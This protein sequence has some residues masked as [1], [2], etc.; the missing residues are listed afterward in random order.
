MKASRFIYL[1][2][3]GLLVSS[4]LLVAC[5]PTTPAPTQAEV[6]EP[7][8]VPVPTEPQASAPTEAQESSSEPEQEPLRVAL[9]LPGLINDGGFNQIGYES[10]M[11]A[12]EKL[13]VD[14][15][16][17]ESIPNPDAPKFLRDYASQGYDVVLGYSGGYVNAVQQVAPEFPDTTFVAIADST[18]EFPDNVWVI[19]HDYM[20]GFFLSG[21]LAGS[22]TETNKVGYIG[23]LELKSY[24]ASS[25]SF[26]QGV[27]Y[28]N[29]DAEVFV[30]FVGDF[31]DPVG[32]KNVAIA[33]A[34][35]GA[36]IIQ[37]NVD[38]GVFGVIEA[39]REKNI[40]MIHY[41]KDLCDQVPDVLL[42]SIVFSY[43]QYVEYIF[44]QVAE[45]HKGGYV[46][47]SVMNGFNE[48]KYCQPVPDDV[49]AKVDEALEKLKTGEA[50]YT[51]VT[52]L[53]EE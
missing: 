27:K 43:P 30:T 5:Q 20:D 11:A 39:V 19:G 46:S 37:S 10:L 40:R 48:L 26:E 51:H 38:N 4:V 44:V 8:S 42:A 49:K 9:V 35:N 47:N 18:V 15:T 29:P 1:L 24:V 28:A 32:A 23:G 16:Y 2:L 22:M 7:T 33:Q 45:G 3:V 52:E 53:L 14:A 17:V 13:G 34:E 41:V 36:D 12:Q 25:M 21:V 6:S 31:N 50:D